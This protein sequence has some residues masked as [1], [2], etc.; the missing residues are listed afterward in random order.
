VDFQ[1]PDGMRVDWAVGCH[2][3]LEEVAHLFAHARPTLQVVV[4]G[5]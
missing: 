3:C 5:S 4:I 2:R 1:E